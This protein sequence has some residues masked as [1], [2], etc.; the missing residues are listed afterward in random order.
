MQLNHILENNRFDQLRVIKFLIR[1]C[2]RSI[3][4][5]ATLVEDRTMRVHPTASVMNSLCWDPL[6]RLGLGDGPLH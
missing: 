1:A 4:T 3:S 6:Y 5:R 2:E